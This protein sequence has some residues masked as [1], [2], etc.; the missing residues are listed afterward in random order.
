MNLEYIVKNENTYQTVKEV[1][2]AKFQVSDRLL[3]KLK[4]N[5]KIYLNGTECNIYNTITLNDVIIANL[6]FD[7]ECLNIVPSKM[8][9][10]IIYEDNAYI[11]LNKPSGIPVHPSMDHYEDSLS[12]G[13]KNY[14]D[15]IDLKRK[16]RPVN[17][18][19]KNTSG[20]VIFAKNEYIQESLIK[21]M[22]SGLFYKE[23]LAI[24][25]GKFEKEKQTLNAPIARKKNSI[26]ERCVDSSGDKAITDY[27]VLDFN[28]K[29]NYSIV[30]C[31]LETGRTHQIRVHMS[32]IGH[33]ILSDTLYGNSSS[34]ISR[35]ALHSYITSFT[36][37]LTKEKVTYTA[38][39]FPDM[40]NLIKKERI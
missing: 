3:L 24:C 27:E 38:P 10:N 35:Q 8:D 5:N 22:K 15:S 17:R 11:V 20:L 28:N 25:E 6:D 1:L 4:K 26:I 33:P 18:L 19:D 9:L 34:L 39:L 23:Y 14:F 7:E 40:E 29:N 13:L 16:I 31:V 12:N 2:K 21:Q 32:Y 36:H 30:K 37:P